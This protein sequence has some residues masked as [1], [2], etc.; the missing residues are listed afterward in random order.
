MLDMPKNSVT[1]LITAMMAVLVVMT[2]V[3]GFHDGSSET[4]NEIEEDVNCKYGF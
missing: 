1:F 3:H 2:D 4:D